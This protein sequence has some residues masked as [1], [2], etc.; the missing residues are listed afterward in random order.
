M[1]G[2]RGPEVVNFAHPGRVIPND[3]VRSAMGAAAGNAGGTT[4]KAPD[5]HV[6]VQVVNVSYPKDV[7]MAMQGAEGTKA[8]I[9]VLSSNRSTIKSLLG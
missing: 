6:P 8:I 1:V 4:V 3:Q 9:N 2:E 5:V 7:P